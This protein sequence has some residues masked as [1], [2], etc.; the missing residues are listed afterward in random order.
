MTFILISWLYGRRGLILCH[1]PAE[2]VDKRCLYQD[3]SALGPIYNQTNFILAIIIGFLA[4]DLH[5]G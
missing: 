5:Y 2:D 4:G 3:S 1:K